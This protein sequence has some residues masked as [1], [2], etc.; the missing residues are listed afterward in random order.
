MASTFEAKL[1]QKS[2]GGPVQ[3]LATFL[4]LR[5]AATS[6]ILGFICVVLD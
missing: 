2:Y 5:R 4:T 6:N 1:A 3:T